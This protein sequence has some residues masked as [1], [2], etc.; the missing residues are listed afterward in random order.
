MGEIRVLTV[1]ELS[2]ILK[3]SEK[4]CYRLIKDRK[5]RAI[6]VRGAIRISLDEVERYIRN[7]EESDGR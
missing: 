3:I 6:W 7:Q 4:T 1:Q 2:R 5:I